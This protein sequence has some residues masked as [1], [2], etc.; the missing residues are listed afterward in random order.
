MLFRSQRIVGHDVIHLGTGETISIEDLFK[1][2]N[3][4]LG[5]K[6]KII[7]DFDRKR[8]EAS[9]V[10]CLQSDPSLAK[11]ILEWRSLVNLKAG[12]MNT[13]EWITSKKDYLQEARTYHV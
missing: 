12:L 3:E 9:E 13:I 8:P 6:A 2:C 5:T 11:K 4:L 7:F 1:L 10:L